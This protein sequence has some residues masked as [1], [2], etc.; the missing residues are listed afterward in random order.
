MTYNKNRANHNILSGE[1]NPNWKGGISFSSGYKHIKQN[2]KYKREHRIIMEKHLNR[3]LTKDEIQHVADLARLELSDD[4]IEK[5][6]EQLSGVLSYIDQLQEVNT[7]AI[8][9]TAQ[10]T[11]LENVLREDSIKTWDKT[12]V[13]NSLVQSPEIEDNQVKV[14]RVL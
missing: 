10:V 2:K 5:Y 11:G 4:E 6:G 9:P 12:E 3:K 7:D 14:K 13:K 8:E 1:Q